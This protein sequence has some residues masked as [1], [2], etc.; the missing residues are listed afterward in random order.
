M[1]KKTTDDDNDQGEVKATEF[2]EDAEETEVD[3]KDGKATE[4]D[5]DGDDESDE[6]D[7][8]AIIAT[9]TPDQAK[10]FTAL[11]TRL[12]KAN[13]SAR[14]RRLALRAL[15]QGKGTESTAPKPTAPKKDDA[16]KG[17]PAFDPEAFKAELLAEF[18]GAQ[19]AT[20]VVTAAQK[21]L[22]RAG[23]ILP[24]DENAAERKLNRVMKMLDLDGVSLDEVA[25]EVEDLKADNPEL[26]GKRAKKRPA[27]GGVGGP[28]RV[29]GTKT[30]DAIAGLFD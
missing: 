16:G 10:V 18:R 8:A 15:R 29:A 22:R 9:L 21:E 20:K 5:E 19:E 14:S 27:A 30:T 3:D 24:D 28:A 11:S 1:A 23:L 17:T 4:S 7:E 26:F 2:D 25:E 12:T 13:A 6:D